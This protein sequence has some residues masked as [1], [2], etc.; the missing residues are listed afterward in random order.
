MSRNRFKMKIKNKKLLV[1]LWWNWNPIISMVKLFNQ[2][3]NFC[4]IV[5]FKELQELH[6][7]IIPISDFS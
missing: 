7:K 4:I 1:V 2:E 3:S 5:L 6:S